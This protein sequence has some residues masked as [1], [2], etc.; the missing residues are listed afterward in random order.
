[1]VEGFCHSSPACN[2]GL[3]GES[4]K[5]LL[6]SPLGEGGKQRLTDEGVYLL[7]WGDQ[8]E[9]LLKDTVC[10]I[11]VVE[12]ACNSKTEG[13][14]NSST[15]CRGSPLVEGAFSLSFFAYL[16]RRANRRI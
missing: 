14:I 6:P 10:I 7:L 12:V 1:M 15:R 4:K 5:K 13:V 9:Y 8:R 11:V 2:D 3:I 16:Q